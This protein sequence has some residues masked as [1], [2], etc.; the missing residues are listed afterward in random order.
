MTSTEKH[1]LESMATDLNLFW[2]PGSWV[3]S[4]LQDAVNQGTLS[5]PMGVKLVMEVV[6]K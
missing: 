3:V 4:N 5:D 2:V 1:H 6:I